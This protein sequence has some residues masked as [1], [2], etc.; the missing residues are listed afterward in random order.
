MLT[1][2]LAPLW[3][4]KMRLVELMF[5]AAIALGLT[6]AIAGIVGALGVVTAVW[7]IAGNAV[8]IASANNICF[9][10]FPLD[11]IMSPPTI[12]KCILL[13]VKHRC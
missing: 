12:F 5:N 1:L 8:N 11:L 2:G 7:A 13:Q 10:L 6:V 4:M 3:S 9:I